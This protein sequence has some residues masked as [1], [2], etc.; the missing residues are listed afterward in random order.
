[1]ATAAE[2]TGVCIPNHDCFFFKLPREIRDEIYR[3]LFKGTYIIDMLPNYTPS[4][5]CSCS[6]ILRVSKAVSHE[7]AEILYSESIFEPCLDLVRDRAY[8][9]LAKDFTSRMMN[10]RFRIGVYPFWMTNLSLIGDTLLDEFTGTD[11]TRNCMQIIFYLLADGLGSK[12][13]PLPALKMLGGFCAVRVELHSRLSDAKREV[14]QL[15]SDHV[16]RGMRTIKQ[17]LEDA[18]GP[19]APGY[20]GTPGQRDYYGYLTFKP[21]QYLMKKSSLEVK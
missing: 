10:L 15:E 1:M 6:K 2:S 14:P 17:Y 19:A 3:Y 7:A 20:S 11:I 16:K 18:L 21:H 9:K 4:N 12:S 5:E 8:S 13:P